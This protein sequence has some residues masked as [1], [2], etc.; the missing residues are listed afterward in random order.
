MGRAI[1]CEQAFQVVLRHAHLRTHTIDVW[2]IELCQC[3]Y[4]VMCEVCKVCK[5]NSYTA[6]TNLGLESDGQVHFSK[7]GTLLP[8]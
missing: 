6:P 3:A 7:V 1:V 2:V 4:R 8:K 5:A